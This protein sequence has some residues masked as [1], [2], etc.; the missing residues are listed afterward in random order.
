MHYRNKTTNEFVV[1]YENVIATG[2]G[3]NSLEMFLFWQGIISEIK[4]EKSESDKPILRIYSE[5]NTTHAYEDDCLVVYDE[6][7][8]HTM[9]RENVLKNFDPITLSEMSAIKDGPFSFDNGVI[10]GIL[11]KISD[12]L[13]T[14]ARNTTQ[15]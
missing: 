6:S 5:T 9:S 1:I 13:D 7:N 12:S 14:I 2:T 8:F 3:V 15:Y 10:A 11:G 4:V